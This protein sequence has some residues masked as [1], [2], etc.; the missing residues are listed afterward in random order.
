MGRRL[1]GVT[2]AAAL[3]VS[4]GVASHSGVAHATGRAM[5][6]LTVGDVSVSEGDVGRIVVQIPI[7]LSWAAPT[8]IPVTWAVHGGSASAGSDFFAATKG[9][10]Q[11]TKKIAAG[12]TEASVKITIFSD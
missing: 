7:D 4:G 10:R 11:G 5:P 6:H 8:V 12:Q 3:A 9:S 1:L 2:L